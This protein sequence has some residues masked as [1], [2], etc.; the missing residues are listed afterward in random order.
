MDRWRKEEVSRRVG[1]R[2]KISNRVVWKVLKSFGHVKRMSGDRL[3]EIM[4]ESKV[5]RRSG[6]G[7]SWT[8]LLDGVK[9]TCIERSLDL[10]DAKVM[11]SPRLGILTYGVSS[12]IGAHSSIG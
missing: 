7:W 12:S 2:G 9:K 11:C 6:R 10:R 3:I 8:R 1:E 4:Y 5:E